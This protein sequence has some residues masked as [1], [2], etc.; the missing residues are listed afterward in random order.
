MEDDL[1]IL[2]VKYLCNHWQDLTPILNLILCDQT[3]LYK[4]LNEDDIHWKII[5]NIKRGIS[6]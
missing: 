2:K 4:Y 5:L 6:Q 3:K 1:K